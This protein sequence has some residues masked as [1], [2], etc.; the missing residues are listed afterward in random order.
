MRMAPLVKPKSPRSFVPISAPTIPGEAMASSVRF[1]P[2]EVHSPGWIQGKSAVPPNKESSSL[3][4]SMQ[5]PRL[6]LLFQMSLMTSSFLPPSKSLWASVQKMVGIGHLV[7]FRPLWRAIV[8]PPSFAEPRPK[9]C[10]AHAFLD[11]RFKPPAS[12]FVL[13]LGVFGYLTSKSLVVPR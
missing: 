3:S 2:H 13:L 5:P 11:T 7:P 12:S 9:S 4:A 6:L 1:V 10:S 8:F